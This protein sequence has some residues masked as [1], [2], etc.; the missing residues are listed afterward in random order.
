MLCLYGEAPVIID[1]KG[2]FEWKQRFPFL[3]VPCTS[4][5]AQSDSA[6]AKEVTSSRLEKL[7][8]A[9]LNDEKTFQLSNGGRR[10]VGSFF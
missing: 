9:S 3:S 4:G 7:R 6:R 2:I 5:T 10:D 1:T 8:R